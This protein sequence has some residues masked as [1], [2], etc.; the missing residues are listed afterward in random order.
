MEIKENLMDEKHKPERLCSEIHL[1]DLCS[2][3]KCKFKKGR[4]CTEPDLLARFEEIADLDD[5]DSSEQFLDEDMD[6]MDD[7][8]NGYQNEYE[9]DEYDEEYLDEEKPD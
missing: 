6:D 1:F 5:E 8:N 9:M 2:K 3:E 7:D 4:F